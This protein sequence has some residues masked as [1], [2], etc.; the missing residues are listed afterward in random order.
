MSARAWR[1]LNEM[2]ELS[3]RIKVCSEM[4]IKNGR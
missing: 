3:E 4:L 2:V 1:D